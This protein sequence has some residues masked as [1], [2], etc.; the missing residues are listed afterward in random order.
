MQ[1]LRNN[2]VDHLEENIANFCK[3]GYDE[4][5]AGDFLFLIEHASTQRNPK[6]D[7]KNN[8]LQYWVIRPK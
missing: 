1:N 5:R 4:A 6:Y 8:D 2:P 7:S 3:E